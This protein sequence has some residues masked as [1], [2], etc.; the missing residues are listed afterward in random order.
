MPRPTR[1][2]QVV[3]VLGVPLAAVLAADADLEAAAQPSTLVSVLLL[4]C[5]ST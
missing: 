2:Q 4:P 3:V 5:F 1:G